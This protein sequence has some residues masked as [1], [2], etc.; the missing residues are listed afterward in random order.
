M[1]NFFDAPK[2]SG[3][4]D[5]DTRDNAPLK[6]DALVSAMRSTWNNLAVSSTCIKPVQEGKIT[7]PQLTH[8]EKFRNAAHR[9][10]FNVLSQWQVYI[11]E[12][13]RKLEHEF[14]REILT[15]KFLIWMGNRAVE[16]GRSGV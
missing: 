8:C 10:G 6:D 13:E 11:S 2:L 7:T 1:S 5:K 16:F 12:C 14:D 3:L 4:P 9:V 15:N